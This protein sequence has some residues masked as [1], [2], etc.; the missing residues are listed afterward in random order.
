MEESKNIAAQYDPSQVEDRLYKFWM[1]NK[2]F[3][4]E[5]DP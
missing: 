3:H 4:A 2:Y 1:D 5:P